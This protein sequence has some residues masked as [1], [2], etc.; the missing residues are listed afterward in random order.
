MGA[1]S[2]KTN[3]IGFMNVLKKIAIFIVALLFSFFALG[4]IMIPLF[5]DSAFSPFVV[6]V[7]PFFIAYLSVKFV[8][9]DRL[10]EQK[11]QL[12]T[13]IHNREE[14]FEATKSEQEKDIFSREAHI[15]ELLQKQHEEESRLNG[16][17]A[18]SID[19]IKEIE[20]QEALRN[21]LNAHNSTSIISK[22]DSMDG[23]NFEHWCAELLQKN[24]FYNVE[25]TP[26][27]GDHGVDVLAEK[28]G[29]RYAIQCK[30]YSHDLG[31]TPV[32]EVYAGKE[33][34]R[35]QVG[36]VMTNR[37]FTK[38]AKELAEKTRVLLWDRDKIQQMI[39]LGK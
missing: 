16:L 33:M 34:Y 32:Q 13:E 27:S 19:L 9:R 35:C 7:V 18:K 25:V 28:E 37:Y 3:P 30:C 15:K 38:G 29:V 4:M 1:S 39:E 12:E 20:K 23:H 2:K 31:N 10:L 26:G 24:G 8:G 5:P 36:V 17:R 21:E 14:Y 11:Q 6:C 22:V